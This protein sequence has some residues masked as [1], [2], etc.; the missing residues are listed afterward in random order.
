MVQ[1]CVD[2]KTWLECRN[3]VL[4]MISIVEWCAQQHVHGEDDYY[5]NLSRVCYGSHPILIREKVTERQ[6]QYY[7]KEEING[8]YIYKSLANS[9]KK[10]MID[11]ILQV[12]IGQ[13]GI[14]PVQGQDLQVDMPNA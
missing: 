3:A 14:S 10:R 12:C 8:Y 2:G 7:S 9:S 4:L 13:D 5:E 1:Y 11:E 6:N